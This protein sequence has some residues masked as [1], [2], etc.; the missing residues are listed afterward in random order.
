MVEDR[1][2]SILYRRVCT[3]FVNGL[4]F[5]GWSTLDIHSNIF[6]TTLR[7]SAIDFT[8]SERPRV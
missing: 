5:I 2:G 4:V 7:T 8:N 6:L 1:A 3:K